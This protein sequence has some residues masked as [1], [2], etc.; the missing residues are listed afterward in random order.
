[1]LLKGWRI[2]RRE[3]GS[4]LLRLIVVDRYGPVDAYCSCQLSLTNLPQ[5]S[6]FSNVGVFLFGPFMLFW[7]QQP[8]CY[9]S[10]FM[11]LLANCIAWALPVKL[12]L[13]LDLAMRWVCCC[14]IIQLADNRPCFKLVRRGTV[15][16]GQ[17]STSQHARETFHR[18]VD[19]PV[20]SPVS[21]CQAEEST[22]VDR[23]T[24]RILSCSDRLGMWQCTIDWQ[25]MTCIFT[26]HGVQSTW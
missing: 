4:K 24:V 11:A 7:N 6:L 20:K 2:Y 9:V 21:G 17:S 10:M 5:S 1:M 26:W 16:N 19:S 15:C 18:R 8:V 14:L 25:D 23:T 13:T 3:A 22:T 12:D